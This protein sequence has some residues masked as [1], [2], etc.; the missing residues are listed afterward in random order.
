MCPCTRVPGTHGTRGDGLDGF[1]RP[2]NPE[3]D[4]SHPSVA[5]TGQRLE[6]EGVAV[7]GALGTRG[8]RVQG[9]VRHLGMV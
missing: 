5:P 9:H 3:I 4:P 7:G 6:S 1:S 2:E 8:T